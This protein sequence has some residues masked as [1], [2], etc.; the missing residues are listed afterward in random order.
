M[1][2][3]LR[4]F[5]FDVLLSAGLPVAAAY[6][7]NWAV[8]NHFR[9]Q[10]YLGDGQLCFYATTLSVVTTSSLFASKTASLTVKISAGGTMLWVV[11]LANV[12]WAL[13]ITAQIRDPATAELSKRR[14]TRVSAALAGAAILAGGITPARY[15]AVSSRPQ[16][17]VVRRSP[18]CRLVRASWAHSR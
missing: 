3:L 7:A 5:F 2:N 9:V 6:I 17:R 1:E 15:Q 4:Y 13:A 18:L 11:I 8:V 14:I 16:R 10:D 12:V